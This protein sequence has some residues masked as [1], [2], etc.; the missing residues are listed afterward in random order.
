M[1]MYY[2]YICIY[3]GYLCAHT[4]SNSTVVGCMASLFKYFPEEWLD[5]FFNVFRSRLRSTDVGKGAFL[6]L[7]RDLASKT[8]SEGFNSLDSQGGHRLFGLRYFTYSDD[9]DVFKTEFEL[10]FDAK[11]S[12]YPS[13]EY[14]IPSALESTA[15]DA[16]EY[17]MEEF[18]HRFNRDRHSQV[19]ALLE[20]PMFKPSDDKSRRH[21]IALLENRV[22]SLGV[23][24][25]I[26]KDYRCY[27][28]IKAQ[29]NRNIQDGIRRFI[30]NV[31]FSML[32]VREVRKYYTRSLKPMDFAKKECPLYNSLTWWSRIGQKKQQAFMLAE[33]QRLLKGSPVKGQKLTNDSPL[34]DLDKLMLKDIA[35]L[36]STTITT[37]ELC[38]FLQSYLDLGPERALQMFR[39]GAKLCAKCWK[40]LS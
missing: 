4:D 13:D 10:N 26:E 14:I 9:E 15:N 22:V 12:V 21:S 25:W 32:S 37:D 24:I 31:G 40:I 23:D 2:M 11:T 6:T 39:V 5:D 33:N 35:Q 38:Q 30:D 3:M 29:R 28:V 27:M 19:K 18:L 36:V 20:C 1:Y 17:I 7:R 34:K 16:W 8:Q